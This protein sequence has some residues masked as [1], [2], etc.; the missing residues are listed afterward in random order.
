MLSDLLMLSLV[1][2][3][4]IHKKFPSLTQHIKKAP[5]TLEVKM[6]LFIV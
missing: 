4:P 5:F 3:P 1:L 2:V 6:L